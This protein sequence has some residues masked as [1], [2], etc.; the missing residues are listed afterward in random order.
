[1]A[2]FCFC[3][4]RSMNHD[5]CDT[6]KHAEETRGCATPG[7]L[8][9]FFTFTLQSIVNRYQLSSAPKLTPVSA[10]KTSSRSSNPQILREARTYAKDHVLVDRSGSIMRVFDGAYVLYY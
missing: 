5:A 10:L 8:T 3:W 1:M 6:H 7:M 2:R 4:S 9:R